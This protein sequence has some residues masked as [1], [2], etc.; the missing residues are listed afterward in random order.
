MMVAVLFS[1]LAILIT[2]RNSIGLMMPFWDN[3]FGWSY[4]LVS[5]AG[6]IMMVVMAMIAPLAGL[7]LDHYGSRLVYVGAV[8]L[9]GCEFI[10]CAFMT[11]YWQL[12][13]LVGIMGGVGFAVISPALVSTTIAQHFDENLGLATSIVTSG[14]T[15]GQLALMP[16][17]GLLVV[18][19]SWRASYLFLGVLILLTAIAVFFLIDDTPKTEIKRPKIQP[20]AIGKTI[21]ILRGNSTFWLL[22]IGFFICGFTTAGVIKIHMIPYAVSCGFSALQSAS[23]YGVMSFFSMVGMIGYGYLSDKMHRPM[24]LASIY[25]LR[26]MTFIL[27]MNITDSPTILFTF[28][29]LFGIFDYA[30]FP[31]VANLVATHI[32][33]KVMGFS[34]GL[35]FA[36]HSLGAA[37]G[38]FLGGYIYDIYASYNYV[39]IFSVLMAALASFLTLFIKENRPLSAFTA[40]A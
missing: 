19:F 12:L 23:A 11:D 33:R 29:I 38:S 31:I 9:I 32:G 15:G 8:G 25:L 13:V 36:S 28:S 7:I 22:A 30:S 20:S 14:S 24:L 4:G 39:W 5:T 26:A 21:S 3:D 27:L 37:S 1:M 40:T 16:L 10:L 35:I 18:S 2:A 34:M 6:A 17:L